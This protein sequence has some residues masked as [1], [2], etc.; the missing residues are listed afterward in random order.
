M[1]SVF[2]TGGAGYVG[3]HICRQLAASG[4]T[5]IVLD[6]FTTGWKQA[7]KFGPCIEVDILNREGIF[8]A[9][10]EHRPDA[11]IHLAALTSVEESVAQPGKYE[12]C[13]VEGTLNIADAMVQFRCPSIVFSSTCAVYGNAVGGAVTEDS[14]LN[15][16]SPY[17]TSKLKAEQLLTRFSR[18]F[19]LSLMI[20][21]Y[22]NV[23]GCDV[24]A[25]IGESKKNPSNLIPAVL[26][27][28]IGNRPSVKIFGTDWP[29]PDGTCIRDYVHATDVAE[30]H[31]LGLKALSQQGGLSEYYNLGSSIGLS[32]RQIINS[33]RKITGSNFDIVE[34]VRRSGDIAQITSDCTKAQNQLGWHSYNSCI[35]QMISDAWKWL[36]RGGYCIDP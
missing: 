9:F 26:D 2:V 1:K 21:R 10:R 25:E 27:C 17:A 4:V 14:A 31:V 20:F 7:V 15:P 18:Q 11:V 13:N 6:N 22:F 33:C 8:A 24:D 19:N 3:S 34:T 30:A 32:V 36:V 5:P 16:N 23:A 35:D 28:A 12:A 29:T